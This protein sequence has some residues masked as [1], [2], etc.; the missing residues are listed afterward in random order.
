MPTS[1]H[2]WPPPRPCPSPAQAL[3]KPASAANAAWT[4]EDLQPQAWQPQHGLAQIPWHAQAW[5]GADGAPGSTPSSALDSA[6]SSSAA[7]AQQLIAAMAAMA[8]ADALASASFMTAASYQP[9][10]Y[11]DLT[12]PLL[13][14]AA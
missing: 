12:K 14:A 6:L 2:C 11:Q 4:L 3:P 7:Q 8:P 1:P 13:A 5:E 9:G 10:S